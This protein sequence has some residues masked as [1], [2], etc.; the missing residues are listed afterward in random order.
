MSDIQITKVV[1]SIYSSN[2]YIF[3]HNVGEDVEVLIID[4]GDADY[5][6]SLL[7]TNAVIKGVLFTHTHFDHMY[8]INHFLNLHPDCTIITNEFG[9]KALVSP[10]L[11]FSR[12]HEE[13]DDIICSHPENIVCVEDGMV[14]ELFEGKEIRIYETPGHDKS[15]IT[16]S[17]GDFVF[18]G[19]AY[20]PG[21]IT[22]ATLPN[23]DKTKV[24]SSELLVKDL[25]AGKTLCPGHG[26]IYEEY[27]NK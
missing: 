21:V 6:E 4:M 11:N 9:K 18:S 25:A 27:N 7:P 20:I 3:A 19:D 5:I 26:P 14:L 8:G 22:R 10:K 2:S 16:Y 23:S 12:Y 15:C 1:N 17:I 13:S 24:A